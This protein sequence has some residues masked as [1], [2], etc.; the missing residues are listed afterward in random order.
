MNTSSHKVL[1][2]LSQLLWLKSTHFA[3]AVAKKGAQ[4]DARINRRA[5]LGADSVRITHSEKKW[6]T[7]RTAF[8]LN[9]FPCSTLSRWTDD[10]R[11]YL[12]PF[13]PKL[14]DGKFRNFFYLI[15]EM[16]SFN[17]MLNKIV[18]WLIEWR[19]KINPRVGSFKKFHR[20][21][22][23]HQIHLRSSSDMAHLLISSTGENQS[24]FSAEIMAGS[25][26]VGIDTLF[27]PKK[28]KGHDSPFF[29]FLIEKKTWNLSSLESRVRPF[30]ELTRAE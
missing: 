21:V 9:Q 12:R 24:H 8:T 5:I 15:A 26:A 19:E 10:S 17:L 13:P 1:R 14:F 28:R 4:L 6:V 22:E 20:I 18:I 25:T 7:K 23:F 11:W 30:I 29:R 3:W 2:N 16:I 27:T